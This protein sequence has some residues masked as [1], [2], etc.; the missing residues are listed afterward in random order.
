MKDNKNTGVLLASLI[1]GFM[2]VSSFYHI[3]GDHWSQIYRQAF[4]NGS[5][6]LFI[7]GLLIVGYKYSDSKV[8]KSLIKWSAIPYCTM[9][10]MYVILLILQVVNKEID[11]IFIISFI[12]IFALGLFKITKP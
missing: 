1:F 3:C 8:L 7:I 2:M 12:L 5:L 9:Q 6:Y 10:L 11:L 4:F